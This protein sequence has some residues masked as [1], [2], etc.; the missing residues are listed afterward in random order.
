MANEISLSTAASPVNSQSTSGT[1]SNVSSATVSPQQSQV[2]NSAEMAAL[3]SDL[4][5]QELSM[6]M[7]GQNN[8]LFGNAL[9]DPFSPQ[10]G[11]NGDLS[12]LINEV[13]SYMGLNNSSGI[14]GNAF[15]NPFSSDSSNLMSSLASSGK[16]GQFLGMLG[17]LISGN[18]MSNSPFG[19]M[20]DPTLTDPFLNPLGSSFDSG[21]LLDSS[22]S[23]VDPSISSSFS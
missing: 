11:F 17:S 1:A 8:G 22:N 9:G 21:T 18:S 2:A 23:G 13:L 20:L 12:G 14:F 6:G 5:N 16:L 7:F 3:S 19:S 10:G 4:Y 15:G